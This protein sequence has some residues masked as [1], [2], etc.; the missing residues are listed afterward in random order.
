MKVVVKCIYY[1]LVV[2]RHCMSLFINLSHIFKFLVPV[3]LF[4]LMSSLF[5]PAAPVQNDFEHVEVWFC[6]CLNHGNRCQCKVF[7]SWSA[8]SNALWGNCITQ[9][10]GKATGVFF[11]LSLPVFYFTSPFFSVSDLVT[12]S[13]TSAHA[14]TLRKK[15]ELWKELLLS[16][17]LVYH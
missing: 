6:R 16:S 5:F 17:P 11:F 7:W 12:V 10:G 14:W 3:L 2:S 4:F 13:A 9:H 1:E 8:V 15:T